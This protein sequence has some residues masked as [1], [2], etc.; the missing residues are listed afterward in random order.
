MLLPG[1][2]RGRRSTVPPFLANVTWVEFPRTLDD[3]PSLHRL[4]S[5]I[6]GVKPGPA[7][8]EQPLLLNGV[9]APMTPRVAAQQPPAG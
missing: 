3:A 1:A 9:V 7:P 4:V 8:G 6:Q 2:E 5:G